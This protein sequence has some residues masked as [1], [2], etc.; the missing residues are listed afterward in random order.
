MHLPLEA[1]VVSGFGFSLPLPAILTKK[2]GRLGHMFDVR[3][4]S[5]TR[6]KAVIFR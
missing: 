5:L 1:K 2:M 3:I 6:D 4:V